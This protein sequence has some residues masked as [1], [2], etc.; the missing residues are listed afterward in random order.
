MLPSS[1]RLQVDDYAIQAVV[2]PQ[3]HQIKASRAGSIHRAGRYQ[4]CGFH[5]P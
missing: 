1:Q 4:H 5:T 2:T 3:T